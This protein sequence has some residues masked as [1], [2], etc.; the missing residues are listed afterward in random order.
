M[1][2]EGISMHNTHQPPPPSAYLQ[3]AEPAPPTPPLA[4]D[5]RAAVAIVG[6][7]I[8]GLST[9]LHLAEA[10]TDVVVLEAR[11]PGWGASGNNGGQLNPGLKYDPDTIEATWGADLGG[12]MIR[13]AYGAPDTAF[14]L[15]RRL[16][17]ACHA[18]QNGTLRAAYSQQG[19][20]G[21]TQ[22]ARQC[23]ARSMPVE[24][25]DAAQVAQ[26]TG[27]TRYRAAM[28]DRR[29]GDVQPL[30]YTRGL[31]R[32]AMAAGAAVHG[33]TPV[34]ALRQEPWGWRI[35]TPRAS[36]LAEKILIATN[37]F[38]DGLWPG[39]RRSIIPVYSAIA[40]TAPLPADLAQSIL[41]LRGSAY[42]SGRITVYFRVDAAG[43]LLMGGRGPMR[44]IGDA[45]QID[46]LTAY[47]GR[48]WP[49]LGGVAWTHG[50]NS[51]L[52]ITKDHWPH[53]HEP[54]ENA[55]IYLG[56]NGR[57]VALATAM[58][59]QLAGRLMGGRDF[60]MD[61]PISLVRP[62]AGHMFWRQAVTAAVLHGRAMDWMG[63]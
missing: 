60:E 36:V 33:D 27:T 17:I 11:V 55:L 38:T 56:C 53:V 48:L 57:G 1:T 21:I 41:P 40:A 19:V 16:G 49:Q 15:I 50:W 2:A 20:A 63:R 42:E 32:A 51:R 13:F 18:R 62:I 25:L 46:Y 24:L 30:S 22:T 47:A 9:A 8:A 39:L 52:A 35:T 31:A 26:L 10:G 61:M 14:A 34:T 5:R 23:Q 43:R 45:A 7:G 59:K 37:G 3:D 54:T 28:L 29:G 58:G 44:P 6:G 12:R 4:A